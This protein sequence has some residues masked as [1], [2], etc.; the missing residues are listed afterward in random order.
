VLLLSPSSGL[1]GGIERYVE[2]IQTSLR[3][4]GLTADRL[5]L[6]QDR[7]SR[8]HT[9]HLGLYRRVRAQL[10]GDREPARL[11]VAHMNLLPTA[12]A[13]A[14]RRD[15]DGIT[16][17]L[18]GAEFWSAT[19]HNVIYRMLAR[20]GVRPV[21]V[22]GFSAGALFPRVRAMVLPPGLSPEW[23]ATLV[24]AARAPREARPGVRLMTSFRLS[25]WRE[26]GL[27]ALVE[28]IRLTGRTDIQLTVC[29]S[30]A[31]EPEL[32]ELITATP[33]CSLRSNLPDADLAA[34]FAA[35]DLFVLATRLQNAPIAAGEG[36]GLVLLEA[37]VAGTPV[38]APAYGGS[39]D[40]FRAGVTGASPADQ[41]PQALARVL[42]EILSDPQRIGEMGIA[43]AA[44]SREQF[45]P[46]RYAALACARLL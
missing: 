44:W 32:N 3:F 25:G 20:R 6:H 12:L 35:A 46:A 7:Q 23:F 1:G 34:E 10:T 38:V 2:T 24:A 29:G 30:G 41:S 21:A 4:L 18:H 5:D 13:A 14:R 40:A 36:F 42:G 28:A 31:P 26:K 33:F 16:V 45:H 39:S 15:I 9:A 37:Q 8:T 43:A 22:S 17:V 11:V 19:R 27:P